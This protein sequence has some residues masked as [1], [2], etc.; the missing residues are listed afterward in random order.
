MIE[1]QA[2]FQNNKWIPPS[3]RRFGSSL[4]TTN[5]TSLWGERIDLMQE[6]MGNNFSA[7]LTENS[8]N[9]PG[10]CCIRLLSVT[11]CCQTFPT[12]AAPPGATSAL[13]TCE[14]LRIGDKVM[15]PD[16]C[17][18]KAPKNNLRRRSEGSSD[19]CCR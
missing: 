5:E 1:Q 15:D 7:C 8:R 3:E 13:A 16:N 12:K 18:A 4:V 14:N 19:I 17:S 2:A 6:T 11:Q 10:N 9:Y